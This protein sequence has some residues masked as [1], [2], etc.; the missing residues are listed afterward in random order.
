MRKTAN[1]NS[2]GAGRVYFIR[3][4]GRESTILFFGDVHFFPGLSTLRTEEP[5]RP[6]DHWN[7]K[8]MGRKVYRGGLFIR[9]RAT[10]KHEAACHQFGLQ[11]SQWAEELEDGTTGDL[12]IALF[13]FDFSSGKAGRWTIVLLMAT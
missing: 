5:L 13:L 9:K 11:R 10:D 1:G 3:G 4:I 8:T 12:L 7:R 6:D 2:F